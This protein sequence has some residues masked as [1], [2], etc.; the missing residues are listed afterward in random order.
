MKNKLLLLL[1]IFFLIFHSCFSQGRFDT[2]EF[3]GKKNVISGEKKT[4]WVSR[5]FLYPNTTYK[6]ADYYYT[7]G[8]N[9]NVR[10]NVDPIIETGYWSQ[11]GNTIFFFAKK[12]FNKQ[13]FIGKYT[14]QKKFLKYD[15]RAFRKKSGSKKNADMNNNIKP[16]I[17]F[18][19]V[20]LS[21]S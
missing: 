2:T 3:V 5:I 10:E 6:K 13:D 7:V 11:S 16:I 8:K 1:S 19:K 17:K 4:I 14:L 9:E 21:N 18:T 20:A 15:W 12:D